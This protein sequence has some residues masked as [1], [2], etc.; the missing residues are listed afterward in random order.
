MIH[1]VDPDGMEAECMGIDLPGVSNVRPWPSSPAA[2][3][4]SR[5]ED[6]DRA[7]VLYR[8][9]MV[10]LALASSQVILRTG[11]ERVTLCAS[12]GEE[13]PA[14]T[15][16]Q[17]KPGCL[18]AEVVRLVMRLKELESLD[19]KSQRREVGG[20]N[21]ERSAADRNQPRSDLREPWQ[22]QRGP[23]PGMFRVVDCDGCDRALIHGRF[24]ERLATA[25]RIATCVN[26]CLGNSTEILKQLKAAADGE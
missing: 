21:E 5:P 1:E 11:S 24:V 2:E 12:C 16:L 6:G 18:S 13:T 20:G 3:P 23:E 22:V 9:A 10:S 4:E 17:H 14:G 7:T 15:M 26:F 19:L 25:E 8:L